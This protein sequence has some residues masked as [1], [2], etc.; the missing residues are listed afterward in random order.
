MTDTIYSKARITVKVPWADGLVYDKFLD[1]A[2]EKIETLFEGNDVTITG[3]VVILGQTLSAVVYSTRQSYIFAYLIIALLMLLFI[4]NLKLGIISMLPNIFPIIITLGIMGA[5]GIVL[6]MFTMLIGSI[7]MGLAV[8]DTIHFMHNYNR[9]YLETGDSD[10]AVLKTFLGTGRAM[11]STTAALS[12]GFFVFT[13]AEMRNL[14]YFGLL[15]GFTLIMALAAD[16]LLAPALVTLLDRR[17]RR[18]Q[19]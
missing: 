15:T 11:L 9:F 8:D 6:D 2:K 13:F 17:K 10:S 18:I 19:E 4:G 1:E 5:F 16:F 14:H 7:A 3:L 12:A